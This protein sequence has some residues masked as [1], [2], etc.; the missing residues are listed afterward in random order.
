MNKIEELCRKINILREMLY[1]AIDK[2]N[3]TDIL[4]ISQ[5]LDVEI[6]KYTKE[7]V[8]LSNNT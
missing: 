7:D 3:N 4:S 6:V 1:N 8:R 2:G 5:E